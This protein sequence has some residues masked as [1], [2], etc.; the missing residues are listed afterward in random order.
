MIIKKISD[1]CTFVDEYRCYA[2]YEIEGWIID[3]IIRTGNHI[4]VISSVV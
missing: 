1:F 2:P 4:S 3:S